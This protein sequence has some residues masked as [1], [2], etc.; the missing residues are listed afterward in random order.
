[1]V[2]FSTKTAK[3]IGMERYHDT[4]DDLDELPWRELAACR[5]HDADLFFP[6]GETGEAALTIRLAKRICSECPVG[7]DCLFYAVSTGQRFGIWGGTDANDRRRLRRRWVA[8]RG[9]VG[10]VDLIG[11]LSK[12]S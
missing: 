8:A 2:A 5:T 6:A 11:W 10:E 1:M 3:L 12:A 7:L 4:Y 9:N